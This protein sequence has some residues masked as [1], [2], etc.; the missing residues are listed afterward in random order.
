METE[1]LAWLATK[2]DAVTLVALVFAVLVAVAGIRIVMARIPRFPKD[3]TDWWIVGAAIGAVLGL[4]KIEPSLMGAIAGVAVGVVA[5]GGFEY[6]TRGGALLKR[7]GSGGSSTVAPSLLLLIG[8]GLSL[9]VAGGCALPQ[10]ML[11]RKSVG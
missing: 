11:D 10:A 5:T 7:L 4:V 9:T 8:L 6:L 1:V 3:F 2:V